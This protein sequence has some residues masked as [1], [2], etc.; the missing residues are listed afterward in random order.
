MRCH[1]FDAGR[2]RSCTL[3]GMP[4]AR[5]LTDKEARARAAVGD[6]A[7]WLPTFAGPEEA[8]RN[9]AKMVVGGTVDAPTLG[10]LDADHRGVDLRDCGILAPGLQAA[11]PAFARF[12]TMAGLVPYDVRERRGELKHVIVT[13]SPDGELMARFVL[14]STEALPRVRKHLPA[15]LA[16]LPKLR[17]ATA[18][19]LPA[20]AAVL[21]GPDE[22]PLTDET[23]LPMRVNS[24]MLGLPPRAFFQTNTAV[25]AALYRQAAEWVLRA[26]RLASLAQGPER[27]D[28]VAERA[29]G[30]TK[31]PLSIWDLYCG[32][33]GFALQVA[34]QGRAVV[35]VESSHDAIAAA[36][37]TATGAGIRGA[38]FIAADATAWAREQDAPPDLVIV[39]PPRRGMGTD[40]ADWIET[41]G[42]STVIYSS[43]NPDTLN[44]DLAGMPSLAPVEARV[45]DMFPQTEHL[46]VMALLERTASG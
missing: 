40:L 37:R 9:K 45:F 33:G 35:G 6:G 29:E 25:A 22:I 21:E 1:H 16:E 11:M 36:A 2:C 13:E 38:S 43:C 4:Y 7:N 3:M 28:P 5:Q 26:L 18:N 23:E 41:S 44:A 42:V 30:E 34:G 31:R 17:V 14:R 10:I 24:M 12:I 20:H 15:L 27:E 32:V 39:N 46:E 19:L 8:Y